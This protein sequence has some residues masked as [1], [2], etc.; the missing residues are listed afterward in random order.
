[1]ALEKSNER[2]VRM[3][4]DKDVEQEQ[5]EKVVKE[6]INKNREQ[7]QLKRYVPFGVTSFA[8]L[9]AVSEVAQ[10]TAKINELFWEFFDLSD[11]ITFGGSLP[12]QSIG[13][14]L[15][16]LT[17]E[18]LKRLSSITSNFDLK[19]HEK[20][21]GPKNFNLVKS[22]GILHWG[23]IPTNKFQDR[24]NPPDILSEKSH[25]DFVS[26]LEKQN[27]DAYPDLYIWHIPKAV[28]KAT[29][30]GYD[31]RGFLVASG[32]VYP[33]YEK[34][35]TDIIKNYDGDI[36]MSHGMW[37]KDIERDEDSPNI[38]TRYKSYEFSFLPQSEAANLL[39]AFTAN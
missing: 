24:D 16:T 11:N 27:K 1:L 23:G 18:Y 6:K 38:I 26:W 20:A 5:T 34:Q 35:V 12:Q 32:V 30:V 17:Q 19:G 9:D 29:W 10:K 37:L 2:F 7:A 4:E 15:V 3:S 13:D 14:A 28:G 21:L 33:Q 25:L 8:D 31:E 39:T 36:G 22:N